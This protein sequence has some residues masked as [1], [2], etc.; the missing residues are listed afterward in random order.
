MF[1]YKIKYK[2]QVG[3]RDIEMQSRYD[4]E[5]DQMDRCS[6]AVN[7]HNQLLCRTNGY[8]EVLNIEKV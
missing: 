3:I 8:Y 7:I 6:A 5:G 1:R 4:I 2:T